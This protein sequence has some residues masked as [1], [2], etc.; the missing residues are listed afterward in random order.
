[1]ISS[2]NQCTAQINRLK[3]KNKIFHHLQIVEEKVIIF[4]CCNV[5]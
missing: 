5:C 2:H 4:A 1:M 3:R